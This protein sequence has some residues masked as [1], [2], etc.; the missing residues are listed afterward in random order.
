M[1]CCLSS[2]EVLIKFL[3]TLE[4]EWKVSSSGALNYVKAIADMLDF[5][6]TQ[7]IAD[8]TL[9]CFT[10]VEVYVRRAKVNLGKRK[11]FDSTR[12]FDLET[13]IAQNS[14]ASIEE[15]ERV[16]PF[17]INTYKEMIIRS[18]NQ[19]GEQRPL[20]RNELVFCTRF[21]TTLLFLRVKCSRP[22]TFQF[23]TI[24]MVRKAKLKDGFIDQTEFKTAK[25]YM[26]D[27]IIITPD[28]MQLLDLYIEHVD[29]DGEDNDDTIIDTF[30]A[31]FEPDDFAPID[32]GTGSEGQTFAAG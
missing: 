8:N 28:V 25:R 18:I 17:H 9:R 26:F 16:V 22:M 4:E 1:D 14:W 13:L 6:K 5:R 3:Q 12:N 2:A 30:D 31:L 27:T 24:D 20:N 29:E 23:L 11:N 19:S 15:M 32:G 10:V 7:G 21:I